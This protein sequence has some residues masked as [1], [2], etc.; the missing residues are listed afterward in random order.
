M[1]VRDLA[2]RLQLKIL[3][4]EDATDRDVQGCYTGDLLSWVMGRAQ[5]GDAWLTVMGNINAIAVATLA[6]T[7]CIILTENAPLDEA[8]RQKAQQQQVAVLQTEENSYHTDI[9]IHQ[10]LGDGSE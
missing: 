9:H 8:A 5:E 1:T 2:E 3:A 7:A 6:D 4:G 10:L